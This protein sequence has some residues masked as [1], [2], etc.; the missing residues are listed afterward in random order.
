MMA[1]EFPHSLCIGCRNLALPGE[2]VEGGGSPASSGRAL[3]PISCI[4]DLQSSWHIAR[5]GDE[6]AADRGSAAAR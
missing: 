4:D 2:R 6:L 3:L 5:A 1:G